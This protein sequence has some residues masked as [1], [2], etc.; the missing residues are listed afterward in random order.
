MPDTPSRSL[1]SLLLGYELAFLGLVLVTGAMGGLWAYFWQQTAAE[2]LRLNAFADTAEEIRTT[3]FQ[4]IKDV[5]LARLRDDPAAVE[6]NT[7]YYRRIQ[8]HFNSLRRQ[9]M[10][11]AEDYAIQSMQEAYG[12]LQA[13]LQAVFDDPYMLNRVARLRILDPRYEQALVADF[14][15]AFKRVRGLVDQALEDQGERVAEWTRRA[16]YLLPAPLLFALLLLFLSRNSLSRDFV[17]PMRE[18]IAGTRRM[19]DGDLGRRLPVGG[20]TEVAQLAASV[21]Q[22]AADLTASRDALI[23]S[24]RQAALG[25]LV[26]VVAHNVRNPLAAIRASAQVLEHVDTLEEVRDTAQGIIST[27]DRLGRWVSALVSYLHPLKPRLADVR[28]AS[29][30]DAV[31]ELLASRLADKQLRVLR[32]P[33]DEAASLRV[34]ADLMEQALYALLANAVEASPRGSAVQVGIRSWPTLTVIEIEDRG[35]GIPFMPDPTGLEPGPTTKRFGTG[36]GI[37]VAFKVCKA[38]GWSLAFEVVDNAGT[39][40]TISAPRQRVQEHDEDA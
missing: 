20:V 19:S 15:D 34:D 25:A 7:D 39:R 10:A 27:V 4:Q 8:G 28:A 36:L 37:P 22:L 38:H 35:G 29:L 32:D 2:S 9:S 1:R 26:P 6:V 31:F 18:V 5:A 17:Q 13:D 11:R 21:N 23:E 3:V 14:E 12:R 40:I 16:P 30:L 33:W 24:E